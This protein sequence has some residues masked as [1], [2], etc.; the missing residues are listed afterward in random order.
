MRALFLIALVFSGLAHARDDYAL[1]DGKSGAMCPWYNKGGHFRWQ[2]LGG[3]WSDKDG[4]LHGTVP[5]TTLSL[6]TNNVGQ[7]VEI[8]VTSIMDAE[9]FVLSGL[10]GPTKFH[11]RESTTGTGPVL[12]AVAA[13]GTETALP[14]IADTDVDKIK[15]DG[16]C[17]SFASLGTSPT[18]STAA[19]IMLQFP[20]LPAGTISARIRMQVAAWFQP[21]TVG[22]YK[23]EVPRKVSPPVT[24]GF[25]A[26]YPND[27]G[28]ETDPAT[29]CHEPFEDLGGTQHHAERAV[30]WI[31]RTFGEP[32]QPNANYRDNWMIDGGRFPFEWP[33][34][35]WKENG[36]FIGSG[37]DIHFV[38]HIMGGTKVPGCNIK[39]KMGKEL[40]EAYVRYY[41]WFDDGFKLPISCDGGKLPGLSGN[42]GPRPC[43]FAGDVPN[44]YCGWQMRQG[45][46]Y[47][48]DAKN[49]THG[50]LTLKTY[51]YWPGMAPQGSISY[52][53]DF[54][55]TDLGPHGN[56]EIGQWHCVEQRIKINDQGVKN[57][58]LHAWVNGRL[59]YVR[60][61]LEYRYPL[62][63]Q[64][65]VYAGNEI[66]GIKHM[67]GN[68]HTGGKDPLGGYYRLKGYD[69]H[70]RYDQ[71][72][73]ATERIGCANVDGTPP[74]PPPPP[75]E[76]C[77]GVDNDGDG[78]IDEGC[79]PPP[80]P[81]VEEC[82]DGIDNDQDGQVD[83]GCAPPPAEVCDNGIDD[84]LD[85]QI[86][87]GCPPPKTDLDR[88][89]E[90]LAKAMD[91]L[92]AATT[93][94]T[95][96]EASL[97]ASE[98]ELSAAQA[99][100]AAALQAQ[101]EA[102]AALEAAQETINQVREIVQ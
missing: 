73:V 8:D 32:P 57:G 23:L 17:S 5:F 36:G 82:G 43:G 80:P 3:D 26:K 75:V 68:L 88:A 38:S 44:G 6:P 61:D 47:N 95:A 27:I 56:V 50:K 45:M 86:D 89:L 22:L 87:E 100:L 84:D 53:V 35:S 74:P 65:P 40:E 33:F 90:A 16:N 14:V 99:A 58:E 7:F 54:N 78:E 83:E 102:E 60:N 63:V 15:I 42:G 72:V 31:T 13:D 20:P 25:A 76:I 12:I 91:D 93:R 11:S 51:A 30:S 98:A 81:P 94:I 101:A 34:V 77:D 19:T 24:T 67:T 96:L 28:I 85:G 62:T 1:Y 46:T 79:P 21:M 70:V 55:Y 10:K 64:N 92:E 4:T 18:V 69:G 9:G 52:G 59:A 41:V 71:V 29:I 66:N 39:G 2:R 49:P 97:A 48:C 37:L